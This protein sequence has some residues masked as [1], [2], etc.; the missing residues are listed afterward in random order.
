[1]KPLKA[2]GGGPAGCASGVTHTTTFIAFPCQQ[3][4][5]AQNCPQ[6]VDQHL[7]LCLPVV[8]P[9]HDAPGAD[10]SWRAPSRLE[11]TGALLPRG[12][13]APLASPAMADDELQEVRDNF[14][15]GNFQ[16]ALASRCASLRS[17]APTM[18]APATASRTKAW[19]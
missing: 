13:S 17:A 15:V 10:G 8:A 9:R 2:S 11:A 19:P 12:V 1:M 16:K 7:L 4:R 14:Y 6:R 5:R 18:W 3:L